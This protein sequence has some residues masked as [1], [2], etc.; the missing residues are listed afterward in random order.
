MDREGWAVGLKLA[1]LT[2]AAHQ[3]RP[4][5]AEV[6][7]DDRHIIDFLTSEVLDR[8]PTDR[9]D[10]L[11][12]TAVLDRLCGSLCDAVLDRAGSSAV[13]EA[14][15]RADLFVVPLDVH[16][17]WYRYHRLFRD[18]LPRARSNRSRGCPGLLRR[19]ADWYRRLGRPTKRSACRSLPAIG[20]GPLMLLLAAEDDFLEQGMAATFLR[21]GDQLG[22]ATIRSDPGS[23]SHGGRGRAER[24]P[25]RVPAL[26]D[27]TEA[28]WPRTVPLKV[29]AA[30]L[31][32]LPCCAPR[33]TRSY[34][35]PPDALAYAEQAASL[36]TDPTLQG[37]VVARITLG[38]VLSGLDRHA[39]AVPVL[40]DA[41]ERSAPSTC[42][43]SSGYR[44][45]ACSPCACSRPASGRG[46]PA[47]P[48]DCT[49]CPG[50]RGRSRRRLGGG[51]HILDHH[52]WPAGLPGRAGDRPAPAGPGCRVGAYRR[53]SE[54]TGPRPDRAGRRSARDR[55]PRGGASCPGRGPGD[56]RDW[57]W[58]SPRYG[59]A[60]GGR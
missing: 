58:R 20:S 38:A 57:E 13:L 9:R 44:Q 14:L 34:A 18:V 23:P 22:E 3:T 1:A 28:H 33:T 56:G 55:R 2:I 49:G 12:R 45:L 11:V 42:R 32:R 46:A 36:E 21:L 4:R 53:T 31:R 48:S 25:D 19:A 60:A 52:R 41:W 51:S 8:L 29:G 16:R 35:D 54:S 7:G 24:Q 27:I 5:A 40:K 47:R 50:N 37:Y 43:C 10:F 59:A 15:E 17:E 6:R 30:S 39:E 26:L